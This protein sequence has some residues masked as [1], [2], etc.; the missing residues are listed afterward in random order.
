LIAIN[1]I[2]ENIDEIPKD[3]PVYVHCKSGGR[4]FVSFSMLRRF[5][6]NAIDIKG[7]ID[8]LEKEGIELTKPQL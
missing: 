1:Q 7:G 5:G 2:R 4:S 8:A 6:I 3:K